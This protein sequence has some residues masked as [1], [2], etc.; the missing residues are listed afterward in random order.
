M[1]PRILTMISSEGEQW[2][3]YN[4]PTWDGEV[5]NLVNRAVKI[6]LYGK[7]EWKTDLVGGWATYP[8]EKWWSEFVSWDDEIPERMEK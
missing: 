4:L 6:N 3:R 1:I 2:A 7:P 5:V 8:S